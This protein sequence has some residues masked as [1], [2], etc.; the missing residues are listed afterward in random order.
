[1]RAPERARR[2]DGSSARATGLLTVLLGYDL[3]IGCLVGILVG[4]ASPAIGI[5]G[6]LWA[7]LA[8]LALTLSVGVWVAER[9][10]AD[11]LASSDYGEL[12]GMVDP[13]HSA[14]LLPYQVVALVSFL[15]ALVMAV[16]AVSDLAVGRSLFQR[17]LHGLAAG[18]FA[19]AVGGFLGLLSITNRHLRRQAELRSLR[20]QLEASERARQ[21]KAC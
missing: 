19:W 13:D 1:M 21:H 18:L 7:P 20:Q 9:W 15:S 2:P 5:V 12:V 3:W 8:A 4:L 6:G 11:R 10:L 14:A 16:A 17:P